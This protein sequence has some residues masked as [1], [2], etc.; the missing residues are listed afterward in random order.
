MYKG[1][2]VNICIP[3]LNNYIGLDT[4]I[5]SIE[6]GTIKPD[7]YYIVDNGNKIKE[8]TLERMLVYSPGRNLGVASSW[9]WFIDKTTE[10]RIILNDDLIFYEDT[11]EVFLD[12][13]S[14][15]TLTIT[16]GTGAL[17]AFSFFSIPDHLIN[18]I[19]KFD[20]QFHPAYF[21]DNDYFRRMKLAGYDYSVAKNCNTIHT[22]SQTTKNFS[23]EEME[24]HHRNFRKNQAYYI[25]K[26]G[27]LP[28]HELFNVPFDKG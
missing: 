1:Y 12:Q 16:E 10:I 26:W 20:Y 3:V 14:E 25:R 9:N 6:K 17:N 15:H 4:L 8:V 18:T 22:G 21:E 24:Q 23:A 27:G 19:G 7:Q 5:E 13:Y 11:L 28:T 2:A